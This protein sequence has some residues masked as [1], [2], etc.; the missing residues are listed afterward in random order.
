MKTR[1]AKD[2]IE[3]AP[4]RATIAKRGQ[5]CSPWLRVAFFFKSDTLL[6]KKQVV[7]AGWNRCEEG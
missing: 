4:A 2:V 3:R 5:I 1:E 7:L 6:N